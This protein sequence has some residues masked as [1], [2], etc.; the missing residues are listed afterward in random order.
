MWFEQGINNPNCDVHDLQNVGISTSSDGDIFVE[1]GT[2]IGESLHCLI[3][4]AQYSNKKLDI[5]AVDKFDLDF[6]LREGVVDFDTREYEH[7]LT[8]PMNNGETPERYIKRHMSHKAILVDFFNKLKES[9][10]EKYLNGCL[11]G[12]SWK[13]AKTFADNSIHFCFIDAG[14]SYNAVK[15]DLQAW[16]PKMKKG[17]VFCGHDWFSGEGV[18]K[19]VMEFAQINNLKI[20]TYQSG[21]RLI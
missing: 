6:M 10:K 21:W 19:A 1:V 11:V 17:G 20:Q 7:P 4:K 15:L 9:G 16:Y 18:R 8:K 12:D 14:H 3:D 2:F 5:Y 13:I